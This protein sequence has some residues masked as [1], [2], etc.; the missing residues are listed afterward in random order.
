MEGGGLFLDTRTRELQREPV[1]LFRA[2][3]GK[4]WTGEWRAGE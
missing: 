3:F 4:R 2:E 1:G